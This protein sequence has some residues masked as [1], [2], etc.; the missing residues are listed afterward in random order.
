V[1]AVRFEWSP[2]R[3]DVAFLGNRSAF[4][5]VLS[6]HDSAGRSTVVGVEVKYH[7]DLTQDPGDPG[8]VRYGEVAAAAGVFR[9]PNAAALRALPLRQ[10]WFD[11]L[12]ALSMIGASA[13][14]ARFVL[15]AP[16]AN[17]AATAVD[18]AYRA[19][20]SDALTYERRTLEEVAAVVRQCAGPGWADQFTKRYLL[21]TLP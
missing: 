18:A 1:D 20:L 19:Q 15:L 21:P 16:A 2:G 7:E 8:N 10:I 5:V 4:D 12:L 3:G 13:D 6:G 9:D 17:P 14:R 11:H